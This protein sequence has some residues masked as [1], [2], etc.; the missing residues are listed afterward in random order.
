MTLNSLTAVGAG[1]P[2][3][4]G[5]SRLASRSGRTSLRSLAF[6]STGQPTTLPNRRPMYLP[7]YLRQH[8]PERAISRANVGPT[9]GDTSR[10]RATVYA[11]QVLSEP[12]RTTSSDAQKVTG[13]QGVAGSNPA[14]PTQRTSPLIMTTA[15]VSG[16]LCALVGGPGFPARAAAWD[17]FGTNRPSSRSGERSVRPRPP[18][19]T[20]RPGAG[21][22]GW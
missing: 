7:K 22:A 19:W 5:N 17:H 6:N 10:C 18:Q 15:Q 3:D 13:G 1:A 20:G 16:H 12:P 2:A 9:S 21:S 11:A 4:R 8:A 14:V